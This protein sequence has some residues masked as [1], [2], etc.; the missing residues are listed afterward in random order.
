MAGKINDN[1][2]VFVKIFWCYQD[3]YLKYEFIPTNFNTVC[4]N[5]FCFEIFTDDFCSW[6]FIIYKQ[7]YAC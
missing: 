4:Q 6:L 3:G 2:I 5:V 1:L 7:I